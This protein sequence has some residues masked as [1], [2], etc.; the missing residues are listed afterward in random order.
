MKKIGCIGIG[1]M[2]GALLEAICKTEYESETLICDFNTER[3]NSF[4]DKYKCKSSSLHEIAVNA[5]YI[6]LGVK[7]QNLAELL[8]SLSSDLSERDTKPVLISM[9]AGV[10]TD[11]ILSLTDCDCPIIRIMPN[12]A[13]SVGEA[14]IL[15]D[16]TK[17]V[18][19]NSL[20][21][22]RSIFTYAG[23]LLPIKEEKID[24]ASAVSGCG[25]A[26]VSMFIEALADGGVSCGLP[27]ST[28]MELAIQTV[29]GTGILLADTKMHPGVLKDAVTSPAGTTIA[30]VRVLENNGFR[31]A[32][33]E[34]VIA[35]KERASGL[36]K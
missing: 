21:D 15:Y 14:V 7:P 27:R 12:V 17:N 11:T 24:A 31:S 22:F 4:T 2:G 36:N 13:A 28:A 6:V 20:D 19:E 29:I 10:T 30:G 3:V 9:A 35:A 8:S 23:K 1:N 26:F 5:D 18:S 32:V 33:M 34:A 25:P 16:H